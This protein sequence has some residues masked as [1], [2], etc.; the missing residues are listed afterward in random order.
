MGAGEDGIKVQPNSE[1]AH[2]S[3]EEEEKKEELWAAGESE[4]AAAR[5]RG[6]LGRGEEQQAVERGG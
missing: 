4:E 1:R 3:E 6:L 5:L 2:G